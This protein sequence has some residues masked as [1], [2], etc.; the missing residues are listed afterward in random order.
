MPDISPQATSI[1][2]ASRMYT[3]MIYEDTRSAISSPVSVSGATR[4]DR[5]DGPT[6]GQSGPEAARASLSA[7]QAKERGLLTSG[8]Y[9]QRS[10]TSSASAALQLFLESRLRA[11]TASDGSTL[12]NLTW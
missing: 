8:T 2:G 6:T 5:P 3:Q 11:R 1:L 12:Y 4:S 10:T 9:G 7:R